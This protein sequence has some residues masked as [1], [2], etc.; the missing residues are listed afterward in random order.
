MDKLYL[1]MLRKECEIEK[2][3]L[4]NNEILATLSPDHFALNKFEIGYYA[5]VIL[6]V[7]YIIKCTPI[8]VHLIQTDKC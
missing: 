4:Q 6:E 7:I 5:K 8:N 3:V 2:Q 1:H